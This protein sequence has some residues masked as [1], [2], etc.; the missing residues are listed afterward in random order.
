MSF[1]RSRPTRSGCALDS[2]V[3]TLRP[4]DRV[5]SIQIPTALEHAVRR[6]IEIHRKK[7]KGSITFH[8]LQGVPRQREFRDIDDIDKEL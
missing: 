5:V 3:S 7:F 6:L 8:C 4:S 2:N 1:V